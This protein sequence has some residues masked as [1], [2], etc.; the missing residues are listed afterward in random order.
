MCDPLKDP[1]LKL[2]FLG[3]VY[4]DAIPMLRYSEPVLKASMD[5]IKVS[6]YGVYC[7]VPV[8]DLFDFVT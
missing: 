8:T 7:F 5:Y 4:P 1:L 3:S 6:N 2:F